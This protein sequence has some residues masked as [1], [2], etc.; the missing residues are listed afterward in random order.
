MVLNIEIPEEI[1]WWIKAKAE[2]DY[3]TPESFIVAGLYRAYKDEQQSLSR[4]VSENIMF[5]SAARRDSQFQFPCTPS[6]K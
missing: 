1:E 2:A 5:S 3:R 4:E 6:D